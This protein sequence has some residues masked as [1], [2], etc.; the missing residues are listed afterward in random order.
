MKTDKE[1]EERFGLTRADIEELAAPWDA[2]EVPGEPM[3]EVIVGRPLKFGEELK[4]VGFKDTESTI[5]KMDRRASSLGMC[6]SDYL[7]WLVHEDLAAAS[8]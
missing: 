5:D 6:R 2:G 3:G 1:I 7:R 8:A 4:I